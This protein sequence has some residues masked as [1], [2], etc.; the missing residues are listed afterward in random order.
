MGKILKMYSK[1]ENFFLKKGFAQTIGFGNKPALIVIDMMNAFTEEKLPLGTNQALEIKQINSLLL[2]ARNKNIPI[3]FT[4]TF[5]EKADFSD[6][7]LWFRKMKGL[8]TLKVNTF[9]VEIDKRL[10]IKGNEQIIVKKFA[11]SFFET[12]LYNRLKLLSIDTIVIVGCTT[13]GCVRATAVDA[14]QLGFI[15]VIVEDAVSDRSAKAHDQS[16]FDIRAKYG[17][18]VQSKEVL[19]YFENTKY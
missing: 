13:S 2:S 17:D 6:A 19:L 7:G 3:F 8:S 15:P 4:K 16:I 1:E 18:I 5:Y 11:S 10:I 9:E 14:I 12:D